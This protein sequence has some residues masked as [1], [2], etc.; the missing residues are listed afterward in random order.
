MGYLQET[1]T[2]LAVIPSVVVVNLV[3][4]LYIYLAWNS[5][6]F[7]VEYQSP[8]VGQRTES[9][10]D[11]S[12]ILQDTEDWTKKFKCSNFSTVADESLKNDIKFKKND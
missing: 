4:A 2:L 9:T 1:S 3:I 7:T 5:E 8:L 10:T 12:S 11:Q 6:P